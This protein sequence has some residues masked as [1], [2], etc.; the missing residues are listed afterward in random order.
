MHRIPWLMRLMMPKAIFRGNSTKPVIYLTFDDGPVPEVTPYVLDYLDKYQAKAT[1]FQVGENVK[2]Y[3]ALAE[4]VLNRGHLVGNH[5]QHHL[6][7]WNTD[8]VIYLKDV[9]KASKYITSRFFRP[10]YGRIMPQQRRKLEKLGYTIVYW[11]LLSADFDTNLS[12]DDCIKI[13][14]NRIRPGDIIV[15]H[16]S[17]KA[18]DR[19]K[20]LLPAVLEH[21]RKNNWA[22]HTIEELA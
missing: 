18:W 6:K 21:C 16:D 11:S 7:G 12:G 2:K 15:F 8:I 13:V 19:L 9:L 10:P 5:T 20:N 22:M 3:P 14:L 4:E 17:I 1:F